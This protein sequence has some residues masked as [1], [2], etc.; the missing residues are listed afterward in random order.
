MKAWLLSCVGIA[1]WL[2]PAWADD[3]ETDATLNDAQIVR[4]A[5]AAQ[6]IDVERRAHDDDTM[7]TQCV[8]KSDASFGWRG[9]WQSAT[10]GRSV[11]TA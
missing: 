3:A 6:G 9:E 1:L 11:R 10:S 8:D 7:S 4:V 2:T 5:I